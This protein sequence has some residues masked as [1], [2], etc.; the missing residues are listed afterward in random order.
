[1]RQKEKEDEK[2]ATY[3]TPRTLLSILRLS[4]AIAKLR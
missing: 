1:M 3:T 2:A 4:Q